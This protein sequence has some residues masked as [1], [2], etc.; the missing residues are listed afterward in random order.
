VLPQPSGPGSY[1]H[2]A[3]LFQGAEAIFA[4]AA[5]AAAADAG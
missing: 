4:G 3:F 1:G 5:G 2:Q